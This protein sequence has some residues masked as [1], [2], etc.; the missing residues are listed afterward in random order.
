MLPLAWQIARTRVADCSHSRGRLLALAWLIARAHVA[1]CS[2]LARA[3][4]ETRVLTTRIAHILATSHALLSQLALCV[5]NPQ[6]IHA[7]ASRLFVV[8]LLIVRAHA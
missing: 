4:E 3:L 7:R 8:D 1:D 6:V 2:C 5:L